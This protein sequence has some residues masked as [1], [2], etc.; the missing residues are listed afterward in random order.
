MIQH[1]AAT[2]QALHS[3][4]P[5]AHLEPTRLP[6]VPELELLLLNADFPQHDLDSQAIATLMD[7]PLYWI[8]CWASGQ[9]LARYL[10]D[11]QDLVKGK[12]V[13]DFGCGCGIGAIAAA[14][15]GASKVYACDIDPLA[16]EIS[17]RNAALNEVELIPATALADIEHCDVLVVADVLYDRGNFPLLDQFLQSAGQVLLAD[18]RIRNFDHPSYTKLTTE[19]SHTWPDLDESAEFRQVTIYASTG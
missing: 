9:V 7:E 5:G 4:L 8:F 19:L 11:H 10:L 12:T 18:S 2:E 17:A 14:K 1:T 15:A 16:L 6:S 3:L 13:I